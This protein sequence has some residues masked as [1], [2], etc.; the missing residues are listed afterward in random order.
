MKEFSGF[1]YLSQIYYSFYSNSKIL[2]ILCNFKLEDEKFIEGF[3]YLVERVFLEYI[4]D[5][6]FLSFDEDEIKNLNVN[7]NTPNFSVIKKHLSDKRV[8]VYNELWIMRKKLAKL[9]REQSL[10]KIKEALINLKKNIEISNEMVRSR[11]KL[12]ENVIDNNFVIE[13][14]IALYDNPIKSSAGEPYSNPQLLKS[15]EFKDEYF[16]GYKSGFLFVMKKIDPNYLKNSKKYMQCKN[17]E[18]LDYPKENLKFS[19]KNCIIGYNNLEKLNF[20]ME[21]FFINEDVF[22]FNDIRDMSPEDSMITLLNYLNGIFV[23]KIARI[24]VN[25]K[26]N[27]C[28]YYYGV[29]LKGK[30]NSESDAYWILF[31]LSENHYN[32]NEYLTHSIK[33]ADALVAELVKN[34]DIPIIKFETDEASFNEILYNNKIQKD[35]KK[36]KD[37]KK[38]LLGYSYE[39]EAA[40]YFIEKFKAKIIGIR[41]RKNE[42]SYETDLRLEINGDEKTCLVQGS[43][44]INKLRKLYIRVEK[45]EKIDYMV[46]FNEDPRKIKED[47]SSFASRLGKEKL[48]RL[49]QKLD[50]SS[51]SNNDEHEELKEL[52]N[53]I[54]AKGVKI[55][56]LGN[57]D[58]NFN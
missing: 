40:K 28:D 44:H 33:L 16:E 55:L 13:H 5:Y 52:L 46:F 17:V 24:K 45:S 51:G 27:R 34:K 2:N 7:I 20:D 42:N 9:R 57:L 54:E 10:P 25:K 15:M 39:L 35:I 11:F 14:A 26:N 30:V 6:L 19:F 38:A 41:E 48:A 4:N 31:R 43:I 22:C 58:K 47:P 56:F 3:I 21:H 37:D 8:S 29:Y 23:K 49:H 32:D 53:K 50:K 12:D 1:Y 36:L 18:L